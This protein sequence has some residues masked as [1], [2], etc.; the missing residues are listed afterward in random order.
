MDFRLCH[1]LMA[2]PK[3]YYQLFQNTVLFWFI[4]SLHFETVSHYIVLVVLRFAICTKPALNSQ[5]SSSHVLEIVYTCRHR[6][7]PVP[8]HATKEVN[9]RCLIRAPHGRCFSV[10]ES[11]ESVQSVVISMSR[12]P[13]EM[14]GERKMTARPWKSGRLLMSRYYCLYN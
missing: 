1:G 7:W 10:S 4:F 6:P 5:S 12:A 11:V 14:T 3:H 13:G 2:P 9:S 8:E